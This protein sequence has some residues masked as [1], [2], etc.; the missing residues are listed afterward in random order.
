MV[1]RTPSCRE[2]LARRQ[3]TPYW[4]NKIG[5]LDSYA[6]MSHHDCSMLQ[7]PNWVLA[8]DCLT[9]ISLQIFREAC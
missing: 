3:A 6:F 5:N 4:W 2:V 8:D 9:S 7:L 1:C